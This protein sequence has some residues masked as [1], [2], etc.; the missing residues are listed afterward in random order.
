MPVQ[1]DYV[2]RLLEVAAAALRRLRELL[3][4]GTAA[5][6]VIVEEAR[7]AQAALFGDTWPLLQRV[8]A[9]TAT[10]LIRDPRQL[11]LWAD[12]LAVEADAS[13]IGGEEDRAAYLNDR[14]AAVAAAAARA[15]GNSQ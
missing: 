13:R 8:D 1:R 5:P 9:A 6:E 12:L 3:G 15:K 2:L 11:A 10:A 4:A 14:A 7:A